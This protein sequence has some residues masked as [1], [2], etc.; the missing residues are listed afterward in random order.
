MTVPGK[1]RKRKLTSLPVLVTL[2]DN[3][4]DDEK[5]GKNEC[6]NSC[7]DLSINYEKCEERGRGDHESSGQKKCP[8]VKEDKYR[9]IDPKNTKIRDTKIVKNFQI[10]QTDLSRIKNENNDQ[11]KN[12][13][14]GQSFTKRRRIVSEPDIH[15]V[16]ESE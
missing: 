5:L 4:S 6:E 3:Q 9:K 15:D 13:G 8:K 7:K 1:T 16:S 10:E 14:E 11:S 12:N 2:E